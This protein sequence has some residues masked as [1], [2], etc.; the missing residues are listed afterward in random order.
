MKKLFRAL[1]SFTEPQLELLAT[2]R[3][4]W[5]WLIHE[6][7]PTNP[8]SVVAETLAWSRSKE[9]TFN[10]RE[11]CAT[12]RHLDQLRLILAGKPPFVVRR[13]ME[14]RLFA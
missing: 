11:V 10:T 1:E 13:T 7:R 3:A 4:A 9:L 14:E 6:E 2:T 12:M 5:N 8:E